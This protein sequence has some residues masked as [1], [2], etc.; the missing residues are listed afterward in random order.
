MDAQKIG[1]TGQDALC[2]LWKAIGSVYCPTDRFVNKS[3][4][5]RPLRADSGGRGSV[6]Y[7]CPPN[8]ATVA[9][10]ML[11]LGSIGL[12]R[13]TTAEQLVDGSRIPNN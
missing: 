7:G 13:L 4:E 12:L 8:A 11:S 6:G 10:I 3:T 5:T 2:A 9:A 1:Q